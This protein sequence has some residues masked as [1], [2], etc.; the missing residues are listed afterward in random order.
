MHPLRRGKKKKK[1][2]QQTAKQS[3]AKT[4]QKNADASNT[5]NNN[6]VLSKQL[7]DSL[8]AGMITN[9]NPIIILPNKKRDREVFL[10]FL[11]NHL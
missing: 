11:K 1:Y 7:Q 3:V 10:L 8:S 4:I 2:Q 5:S 9:D 6:N